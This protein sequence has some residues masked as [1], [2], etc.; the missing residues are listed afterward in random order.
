MVEAMEMVTTVTPIAAENIRATIFQLMETNEIRMRRRRS[1]APAST[2]APKNCRS[3]IEQAAEQEA[4]KVAQL[5]RT[6]GKMVNMLDGQTSLQAA[7]WREMK[8]C[9]EK[10]QEKWDASHQDDVLSGRGITGMV[11]R[12]LAATEGG[13]REREERKADTDGAGLEASIHSDA[14]QTGGPEKPEERQQ[15]QSGR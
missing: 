15:S 11:P 8:T 1:E 10:T 13:Q 9:L 7:Q 6:I 14:T 12:V 5:D 2:L 3:R 4:T